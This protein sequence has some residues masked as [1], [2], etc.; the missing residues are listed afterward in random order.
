MPT[1]RDTRPGRMTAYLV[2][3]S[4]V[5]LALLLRQPLWPVMG[6]RVPFMTFFPAVML[7]AYRGGFRPGILATGLASVAASYFLLDPTPSFTVAHP[8]DILGLALFAASGG[9]IS[10][11][12]ESLRR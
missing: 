10:H 4:A 8:G 7:A 1:T 11:L 5:A 2:A 9:F 12:A 3:V 6:N